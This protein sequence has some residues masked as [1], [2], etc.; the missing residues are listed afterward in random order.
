MVICVCSW[1][2]HAVWLDSELSV[3][4]KKQR[5]REERETLV[6]WK[7]PL[8]TLHYFTLEL[9]ITLQEWIWRWDQ[10]WDT[11]SHQNTVLF[12][13]TCT[14]GASSIFHLNGCKSSLPTK[15]REFNLY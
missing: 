12:L 15:L 4:E 1:N 13:Q 9:I 14:W 8:L 6:L 7:K 5:D 10:G 2:T 11:T 3:D